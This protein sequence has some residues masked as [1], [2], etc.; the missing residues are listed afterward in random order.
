MPLGMRDVSG[1]SA[2]RTVARATLALL[3][4][5]ALPAHAA[6]DRFRIVHERVQLTEPEPSWLAP[7]FEV[8]AAF[9]PVREPIS[10]SGLRLQGG[11]SA[12]SIES[13]TAPGDAIFQ[14]SFE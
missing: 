4:A 9:T 7:R 14:D 1:R 5:I 13:C 8:H 11:L 10:G 2:V 6:G 12:K 3:C